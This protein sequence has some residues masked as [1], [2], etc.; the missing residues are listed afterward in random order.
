MAQIGTLIDRK[1]MEVVLQRIRERKPPL[2]AM[3]PESEGIIKE[4][5]KPVKRKRKRM[6]KAQSASLMSRKELNKKLCEAAELGDCGKIKTLLAAGADVNCRRD[7]KGKNTPLILA[8]Y[9][10]NFNAAKLL[11][12]KGANYDARC[13]ET[14]FTALFWAVRHGNVKLVRL[15]VGNGAKLNFRDVAGSTALMHAGAGGK[16]EEILRKAGATE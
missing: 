4:V 9:R 15:L 3:K 2:C 8:V 10:D 12:W 16:C 13:K 11:I 7:D 5:K 6:A 14:G 1:K